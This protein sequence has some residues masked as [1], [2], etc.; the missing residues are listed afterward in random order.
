[1]DPKYEI[2]QQVK[3]VPISGS[4]MDIDRWLGK[5]AGR[6]G[7]VVRYYCINQDEMPD[8]NKMYVYPDVY[9]YDIRL[10]EDGEIMRGI[11]EPA[12]ESVKE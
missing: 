1:M 3:F 5:L 11:P 4:D 8:R 2:G 12:L 10:D 6:T 9:S 7:T